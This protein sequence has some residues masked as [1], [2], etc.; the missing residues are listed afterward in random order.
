MKNRRSF[1]NSNRRVRDDE[2]REKKIRDPRKDKS[3][4]D[5]S[6]EEEL[7][8]FDPDDLY[9]DPDGSDEEKDDE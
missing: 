2:F 4:R 8:E 6:L 7:E 5:F 9:N 3:N 1:R